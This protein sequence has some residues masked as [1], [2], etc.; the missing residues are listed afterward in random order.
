MTGN[1]FLF[2]DRRG[3]YRAEIIPVF[4]KRVALRADRVRL[5]CPDFAARRVS[6]HA[7]T[8]PSPFQASSVPDIGIF[9]SP[10]VC[11]RRTF[12]DI[13]SAACHRPSC[14]MLQWPCALQ[15]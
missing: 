4:Y 8:A 14:S 6:D 15:T 5:Q 12:P 9:V 1:S 13:I 7:A 11:A 3:A 10:E 2:I